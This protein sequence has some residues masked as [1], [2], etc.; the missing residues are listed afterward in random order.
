MRRLTIK[1]YTNIY[2]FIFVIMWLMLCLTLTVILYTEWPT[3]SYYSFAAVYVH[4]LPVSFLFAFTWTSSFSQNFDKIVTVATI[5]FLLLKG[6]V[7]CHYVS[8]NLQH[9]CLWFLTLNEFPRF[10][11]DVFS[12]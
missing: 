11:W 7:A 4:L 9:R 8:P 2:R 5:C 10:W 1:R 3:L 6:F 12:N